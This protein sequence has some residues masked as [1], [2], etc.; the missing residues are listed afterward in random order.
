[1]KAE[2]VAVSA[3][4]YGTGRGRRAPTFGVGV[5]GAAGWRLQVSP[6]RKALELFKTDELKA[7]AAYDWNGTLWNPEDT[8]TVL[9]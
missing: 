5:G 6:G 8:G 1:M 4:I 3:R 7:S 2:A 9:S